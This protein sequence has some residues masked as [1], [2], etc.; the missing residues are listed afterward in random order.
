MYRVKIAI[1]VFI[2]KVMCNTKMLAFISQKF[3]HSHTQTHANHHPPQSEQKLCV[4]VY[5]RDIVCLPKDYATSDGLIEL[6]RKK[7]DRQ[8][9]VTNKLIG[10][11][12]LRSEMKEKEIF[13]EIRSVFRTPMGF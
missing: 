5:D 11:I 7:E 12:Q 2:D 6:L 3:L 8:F 4:F 1:H 9:L 10:K 13:K